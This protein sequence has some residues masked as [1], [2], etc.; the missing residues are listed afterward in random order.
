[1]NEDEQRER[2]GNEIAALMGPLV[3]EMRLRFRACAEEAGFAAGD[4]QALWLL[5]LAGELATKDLAARL[6]IDPANASS[7]LTRLERRGLVRREPAE[8]DRRRRLVALTDEGRETRAALARCIA[9][10]EPAFGRLSTAELTTFRDLLRRVA[11]HGRDP[12]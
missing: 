6:G 8:H 10:G 9:A 4:A 3:R 5:E 1:M 11:G 2:L 7:L 12:V